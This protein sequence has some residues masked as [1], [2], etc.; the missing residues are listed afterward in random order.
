MHLKQRFFSA[1]CL[2]L[3]ESLRE[4]RTETPGG[5]NNRRYYKCIVY[6]TNTKYYEISTICEC[7]EKL[8]MTKGCNT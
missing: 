1:R 2:C 5:Q 7:V 8:S 4:S 3:M 6:K